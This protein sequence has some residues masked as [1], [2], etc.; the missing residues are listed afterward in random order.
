M[1]APR[2]ACSPK[3][4]ALT[5]SCRAGSWI[6]KKVNS[7]YQLHDG[8]DRSGVKKGRNRLQRLCRR[9]YH[10]KQTMASKDQRPSR[11][12]GKSNPRRVKIITWIVVW[13]V[14]GGVVRRTDT[15]DTE[16]KWR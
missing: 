11:R 13:A 14:G 16:W 6:K 7:D 10:R 5:C 8:R 15:P 12:L 3:K 2:S 9:V 1:I 4:A